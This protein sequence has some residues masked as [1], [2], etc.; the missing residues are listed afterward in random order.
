MD[1]GALYH[2]IGIKIDFD[3]LTKSAGIL[4]ANRLAIAECLQ[5]WITC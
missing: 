4:V 2:I 3:E 1:V 5:D